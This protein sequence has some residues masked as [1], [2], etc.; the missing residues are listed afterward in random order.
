MISR[1]GAEAIV[2]LHFAFV[3]FVV[4]GG[5]LVLRYRRLAILHLPAV[6]WGIYIEL[7]GGLC[8][9]TGVENRLRRSAGEAGYDSGFI[10][11]YI[12]PLLYPVGL[13]PDVQV[14]LA[15][16]LALVN[17]L[18]YGWIAADYLRRRA[19]R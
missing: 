16:L 10:E 6:A 14:W 15:I 19:G 1:L 2:L 9:L 18:V 8:P 5:L 4:L 11:H 7:T 13:T 17:A 12:Y 3:L